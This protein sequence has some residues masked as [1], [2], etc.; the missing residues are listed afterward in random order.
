MS[1]VEVIEA[2]LGNPDHQRA[3]LDLIGAYARDPMETGRD[4]PEGVLRNLVPALRSHPT[5]MI[6]LAYRGANPVG[7][8][9]CFLG[10]STFKARPP[11]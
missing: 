6:F 9:V 11:I 8:A 5:T 10:F 3:V 2:D 1:A 4:L 7:I